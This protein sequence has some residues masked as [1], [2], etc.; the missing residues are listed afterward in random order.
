MITFLSPL[1]LF[2]ILAA[3][4]QTGVEYPPELLA[5]RR[6]S[7]VEQIHEY[8]ADGAGLYDNTSEIALNVAAY[9]V[10]HVSE[11]NKAWAEQR[12]QEEQAKAV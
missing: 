4:K 5:A 2:D 8:E 9:N 11:K 7:F 10:A 1:E 12:L 3:V 6:A